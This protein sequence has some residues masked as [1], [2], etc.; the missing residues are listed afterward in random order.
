MLRIAGRDRPPPRGPCATA[1]RHRRA[2]AGERARGAD[3]RVVHGRRQHRTA[4]DVRGDLGAAH[5][6][7]DAARQH[8]TK[9]RRRPLGLAR[10]GGVDLEPGIR[11]R[12][13]AGC[14]V[15]S[16]FGFGS[17]STSGPPGPVF[18]RRVFSF[19]DCVRAHRFRSRVAVRIPRWDSSAASSRPSAAVS[20]CSGIP[21][22]GYLFVPI[23]LGMALA[24]VTMIAARHYWGQELASVASGS[25]VLGSFFLGIMTVVGGVVLFLIAQPLLLAVFSDQLS[26]R[27]ETR[28]ARQGAHGPVLHVDGPRAAPRAAEARPLRH[29]AGGRPRR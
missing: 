3:A 14:R 9:R 25:P 13:D 26:E 19:R 6:H 4:D 22:S 7:R 8:R 20:T 23:I 27:V 18:G 28:R 12:G 5:Q 16:G 10:A 11:A 29:R 21:S 24:V 2:R 1:G 17:G 15:K